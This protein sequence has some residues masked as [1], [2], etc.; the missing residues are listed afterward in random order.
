[1]RLP[2][3]K[4]L[5]FFIVMVLLIVPYIIFGLL[6]VIFNNLGVWT[7]NLVNSLGKWA[8]G[9]ERFIH[10]KLYTN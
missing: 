1:M 7:M 8:T 6:S 2:T 5:I 10:F 4:E 9:R 3:R